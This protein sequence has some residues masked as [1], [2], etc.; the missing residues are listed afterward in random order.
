MKKALLCTLILGILAVGLAHQVW[1]SWDGCH[2]YYNSR[3]ISSYT[4]G[5]YCGST[6]PG[7]RECYMLDMSY[8]C[9]ELLDGGPSSCLDFQDFPGWGV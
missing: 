3:L 9:I 5:T 4:D 7:C 6:G 8:Y 2:V 1:A